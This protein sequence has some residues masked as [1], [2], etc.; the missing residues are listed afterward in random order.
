MPNECIVYRVKIKRG[1]PRF[2]EVSLPVTYEEGKWPGNEVEK[3]DLAFTTTESIKL[4]NHS[5]LSFFFFKRALPCKS[6]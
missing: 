4:L 2:R 5:S 6:V 1:Q 3:E